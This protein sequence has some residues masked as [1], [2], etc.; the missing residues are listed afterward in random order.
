MAAR[1]VNS[2]SVTSP[3]NRLRI[4]CGS[5]NIKKIVDNNAK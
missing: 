1:D 5:T 2:R 4:E 3:A